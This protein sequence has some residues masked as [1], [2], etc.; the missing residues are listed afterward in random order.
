MNSRLSRV[1]VA[2][3]FAVGKVHKDKNFVLRFIANDLAFSRF[4]V[5]VS[6]KTGNAVLRNRIK[7]RLRAVWINERE[8]L[9]CGFDFAII[10]NKK[11]ATM[12]FTELSAA[13][14]RIIQKVKS[15]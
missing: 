6:R 13:V 8:K 3:L 12:P 10:A 15:S 11:I 2:N 5:I 9:P 4:A 1:A 7:R 14:L